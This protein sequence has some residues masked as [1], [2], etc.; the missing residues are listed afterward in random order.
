VFEAHDD[1]EP[2]RRVRFTQRIV[3]VD[4]HTSY[5]VTTALLSADVTG[6]GVLDVIGQAPWADVG[7]TANSGALYV[8][9]GS[10]APSAAPT[11]TLTISASFGSAFLGLSAPQG[12]F[13]EDVTGDGILDVIAT[14]RWATVNG[15]AEA[16]AAFIWAGGPGLTGSPGPTATLVS[17]SPG[18]GDHLS[19]HPGA[20]F[21]DLDA[22]GTTDVFLGNADAKGEIHFWRGGAALVGTP[23]P[24]ATLA[25]V[26]F[27]AQPGGRYWSRGIDFIDLSGDGMLD[28]VVS[29]QGKDV[30]G[31][32]DAGAILVFD[33]ATLAGLPLPYATLQVSGA[34]TDDRLGT[35][36][37]ALPIFADVTGDGVTDVVSATMLTDSNKQS[38]LGAAYVWE[39][40]PSLA[41]IVTQHATLARVHPR[42]DD[43][44][45]AQLEVADVTGDGIADVL[46]GSPTFDVNGLVDPGGLLVFEGGPALAGTPAA[47]A[48]LVDSQAAAGDQLTLRALADLDGDGVLD[49]VLASPSADV[50]GVSDVGA[51]KIW[52]G[53]SGLVGPRDPSA[54]LTPAVAN[55]LDALTIVPSFADLDGDGRIDVLGRSYADVNGVTNAGALLVFPGSSGWSGAVHESAMLADPV[56][57]ASGGGFGVGNALADVTGD[58]QLDVVI[59]YGSHFDAASNQKGAIF[60]FAGGAGLSGAVAPAATLLA[61]QGHKGDAMGSETQLLDLDDDGVLD[62]V[63][64]DAS[65]SAHGI[66]DSGAGYAWYGGSRLSGTVIS[67]VRFAVT[68]ASIS[69][70]VTDWYPI[71]GGV[72][73]ADVTGDGALEFLPCARF[74]DWNG[75]ADVGVLHVWTSPFSSDDD[76]DATLSVPGAAAGDLMG[77]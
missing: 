52:L 70:G 10:T 40:G 4:S 75:V 15:F 63:C 50:G 61:L 69:D 53:G 25:S 58:G 67:D 38:D 6:D 39:G 9:A 17:P 26:R 35:T 37:S 11:A 62:V 34:R 29:S 76:P 2:D 72:F 7:G 47:R 66:L 13:T 45:G 3:F 46:V 20:T 41:G 30:G 51:I 43:R 36:E 60:V 57:P 73:L 1:V 21:I 68:S 12:S 44:L 56:P 23:L 42:A 74:A 59:S 31:V 64:G 8:W 32:K 48:Y 5:G 54:V 77:H 27:V 19:E 28:V 18:T 22:D 49:I 71:P 33:G 24:I 65:A 55:P 16:G 14:S